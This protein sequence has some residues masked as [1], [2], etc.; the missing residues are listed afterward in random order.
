MELAVSYPSSTD[1]RAVIAEV[2]ALER[3]GVDA[4]WV[5]ESYGFD[6]A[7]ALGAMAMRTTRARLGFGV[8]PVQTRSSALIAMTAAGLDRLS[9]GRAILGLGVSGARVVEGWHGAPYRASADTLRATVEA[10]RSIWRREPMPEQLRSAEARRHRQLK[11]IHAPSRQGIPVYLATSGE[12]NV[13]LTAEI[14]EGWL[15]AFL[16]PEKLDN[17]W[18]TAIA[19]GTA[20][21]DSAL[22]PL[23]IHTGVYLAIEQGQDAALAAHRQRLAHYIGGMGSPDRN[24]YARIAALYGFDREVTRIQ[25]LYGLG[26]REDAA[27]AVPDEL[28]RATCVIGSEA[29]AADRLHAFARAGVTSLSLSFAGIDLEQRCAQIERCRSIVDTREAAS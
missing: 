17:V 27:R 6:S 22:P 13:A 8:M 23:A 14:A 21:R 1:F 4:F 28:L 3:A 12:R 18:G 15:A 2:G 26:Q 5:G 20:L 11:L 25:N 19:R 29:E 7:T 10:A 9:D 24:A 16:V